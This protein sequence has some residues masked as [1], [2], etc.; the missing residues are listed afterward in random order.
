MG[1]KRPA[2]VLFIGRPQLTAAA[3]QAAHELGARWLEPST[4][5]APAC[6]WAD[7]VITLGSCAR[8]E[9]PPLPPTTRHK[10]WDVETPIAVRQRVEGMVGGMRMLHRMSD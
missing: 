5:E 9:A 4:T 10:H 2:R 3:M 8:D 6:G 1:Y 7:L